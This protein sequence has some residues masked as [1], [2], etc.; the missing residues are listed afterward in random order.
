MAAAWQQQDVD[1]PVMGRDAGLKSGVTK[2][3]VHACRSELDR[4]SVDDE[5]ERA[6]AAAAAR[7]D[8]N[9][10]YAQEEP[11]HRTVHSTL[12]VAERAK[13]LMLE[14]PQRRRESGGPRWPSQG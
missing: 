12:A 4:V 10:G 11:D 2:P 9:G 3:P 7:S 6:F 14:L 8:L 1:A 13:A 5:N